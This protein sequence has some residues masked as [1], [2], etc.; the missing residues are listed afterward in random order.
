[1]PSAGELRHEIIA[2]LEAWAY[3]DDVAAVLLIGNEWP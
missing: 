1:M 2:A 3:D